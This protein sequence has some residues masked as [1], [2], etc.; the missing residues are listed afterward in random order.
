[1]NV[2]HIH[3]KKEVGIEMF[4]KKKLLNQLRI[5]FSAASIF[6]SALI[7]YMMNIGKLE[8][9]NFNV[10]GFL[11]LFVGGYIGITT[12]AE[13]LKKISENRQS[14]LVYIKNTIFITLWALGVFVGAIVLIII[15]YATFKISFK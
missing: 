3:V 11:I 2:D 1:M 5:L 13:E 15:L 14:G 10:L 7:F 8:T 12:S 9:S 4:S 6:Y